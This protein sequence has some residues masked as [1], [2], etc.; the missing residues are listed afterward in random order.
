VAEAR[1][2]IAASARIL[3]ALDA[4]PGGVLPA[5]ST[6]PA[7]KA[8][9]PRR[10]TGA[11]AWMAA[12]AVLV[13]STVTVIAKRSGSDDTL[14]KAVYPKE[15]KAGREETQGFLAETAASAVRAPAAAAAP[16]PAEKSMANAPARKP[17]AGAVPTAPMLA[18]KR[19]VRGES[20]RK[21]ALPKKEA[22]EAPAAD[23]AV[24][25]DAMVA[26]SASPAPSSSPAGAPAAAPAVA[27]APA[28]PRFADSLRER[29]AMLNSVVVTGGGTTTSGQKLGSTIAVDS[30]AMDSASPQLL[31]RNTLHVGGDT[32]VTTIY[33]VRGVS[34]SLIDHSAPH[35]ESRRPQIRGAVSEMSAESRNAAAA[36]K[37]ISWS[38]STGHTHVLRGPLT[39]EQLEQ[40]KKALFGA[41]P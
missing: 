8:R 37:S 35:D 20:E 21:D 11:R 24:A 36:V 4:V 40:L 28:P 10:F 33:T 30:T 12:A 2:F 32:V 26:K 31:S 15:Q 38:D 34:V 9:T 25:A 3:T 13:L 41:T 39:Q 23:A 7:T 14:A 1:G 16:V 29:R 5:Q 27:Q 19:D 17:G 22:N 18:D 6:A